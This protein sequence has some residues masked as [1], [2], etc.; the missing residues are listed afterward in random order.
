MGFLPGTPGGDTISERCDQGY[1]NEPDQI[2]GYAGNDSLSGLGGSDSIHG[3][4]DNDTL[5]GSSG[6]DFLYGER[7]AIPSLGFE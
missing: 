6:N 3:G 7:A 4:D 5:D 2:F 1:A